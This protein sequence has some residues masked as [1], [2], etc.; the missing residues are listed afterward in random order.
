[1]FYA[2]YENGAIDMKPTFEMLHKSEYTLFYA[3]LHIVGSCKYYY[4]LNSKCET[5]PLQLNGCKLH[6]I[7]QRNECGFLY[8]EMEVERPRGEIEIVEIYRQKYFYF[9]P[10]T[11]AASVIR[12]MH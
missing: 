10:L 6:S 1:M 5:T 8:V 2:V 4:L 7:I 12:T 3:R 11:I 9:S